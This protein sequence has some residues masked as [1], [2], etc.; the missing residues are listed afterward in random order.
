MIRRVVTTLRADD[1]IAAAIDYYLEEG[2]PDAALA[3]VDEL[4]LTRNVIAQHPSIGSS[5]FAVFTGIAELRSVGLQRFPY[6]VLYTD[7]AD[8]VRVHRV[9]H[10]SRD[11]PAEIADRA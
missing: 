7:D 10:T 8:A 3:F 4:E 9:L 1:D 6:L 2:A 11:I 5:R